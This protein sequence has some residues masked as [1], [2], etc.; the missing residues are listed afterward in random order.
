MI[1]RLTL[2]NWRAYEHLQLEFHPGATFVVAPNGVGKSSIVEGARFALFGLVP[3]AKGGASRITRSGSTSASVEVDLPSG[4]RLTVTRPYPTKPRSS[5]T[6]DVL[7]DG[8]ASPAGDL[9]ALLAEEYGAETTFL[10]RLAMLHSSTVFTETKGLDLREHLCR[11]FGVDGL[12]AA[13]DQ[14]KLLAQ[15]AKKTV[16]LA[17]KVATVPEEE[18]A[19]LL[20]LEARAVELTEAAGTERAAAEEELANARAAGELRVRYDRW[21]ATADRYQAV[22]NDVA[23]EAT[24][25]LGRELSV[26]ALAADLETAEATAVEALDLVRQRRAEVTGHMLAIRAG[27]AELESAEG[28]CPVCRRPLGPGDVDAARAGHEQELAALEADLGLLDEAEP[29]RLV[30]GVRQLRSRLANEPRP[31]EPPPQPDDEQS[32]A[33]ESE[34]VQQFEAAVATVAERRAILNEA[35]RRREAAE[36][37][38][39]EL[40]AVTTAFE[41]AAA[42]EAAASALEAAR[43]RILDESIEPLE[44]LLAENWRKLFVDR[45]GV[46]LQGDGTVSRRIGSEDLEYEHFSDGEK[47]VAQLILRVLV[48][49]ATTRLGFFWVDEPLEHLDPDVRRALAV[50]LAQAP[51]APSFRQVLVTTYEEPLIRR[52]RASVPNTHLIYVRPSAPDPLPTGT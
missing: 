50:L 4:R 10:A 40:E 42:L 16:D 32:P 5:S 23:A 1:R 6:L 46:G 30:E 22:V 29:L 9:D 19:A 31:G 14:T 45:P 28:T 11:V 13:L 49:R 26:A 33:A 27:V 15:A 12:V 8:Q 43:Q 24:T 20:E 36:S 18:L 52:L 34:A 35:R 25:L 39:V 48:L 38:R 41:R 44:D 21:K 2:Q 47:M 37:A 7:V 17:R 3:P 51:E